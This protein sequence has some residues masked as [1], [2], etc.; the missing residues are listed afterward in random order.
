MA[1]PPSLS[2]IRGHNYH[3]NELLA[4]QSMFRQ[5]LASLRADFNARLTLQDEE[6]RALKQQMEQ[7]NREKNALASSIQSFQFDRAVR[8]EQSNQHHGHGHQHSISQDDLPPP[9]YQHHSTDPLAMATS[10]RNDTKSTITKQQIAHT[11][12]ETVLANPPLLL[13]GFFKSNDGTSESLETVSYELVAPRTPLSRGAFEGTA[14]DST[15]ASKVTEG[16]MDE[17]TGELRFLKQYDLTN[18]PTMREYAGEFA[19]L[20]QTDV[21]GVKGTWQTRGG[22]LQGKFAMWLASDDESI[23]ARVLVNT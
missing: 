18:I 4:Q 10:S 22:R 12:L 1:R 7:I 3:H 6:I 15:G 21:W 11:W 14:Q 23:D 20:G 9:L 17:T 8:T 5:E 19:L 13:T 2:P 16:F